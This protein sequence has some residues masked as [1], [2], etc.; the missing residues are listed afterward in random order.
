[1]TTPSTSVKVTPISEHVMDVM[2]LPNI[3]GPP[4]ISPRWFG[5]QKC[6]A[7]LSQPS[8]P[9]PPELL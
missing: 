8:Q 5:W 7:S 1:M 2:E 4:T 9:F 6:I 3:Y